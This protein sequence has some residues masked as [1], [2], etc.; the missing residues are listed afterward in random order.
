MNR[1]CIVDLASGIVLNEIAWN[2]SEEFEVAA[3]C[4]IVPAS[5]G[6]GIGGKYDFDKKEFTPRDPMEQMGTEQP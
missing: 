5:L 1:Y 2:G 6:S 3:G 4:V